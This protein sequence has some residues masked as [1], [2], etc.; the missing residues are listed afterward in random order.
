MY[1]EFTSDY[2]LVGWEKQSDGRLEM[3]PTDRFFFA[4]QFCNLTPPRADALATSSD[5]PKV[6]VTAFAAGAGP[7]RVYTIHIANLGPS[8][9]AHL[10]GLPAGVN[11]FRAICTNAS[12]S[13][14]EIEPVQSTASEAQLTLP[15]QSLLTLTNM[16]KQ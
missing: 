14:R 10:T 15:A 16:P 3:F 11:Q 7:Q 1:W 13:F 6:L 8:A 9:S 5:H 4:K 2:S 12:D